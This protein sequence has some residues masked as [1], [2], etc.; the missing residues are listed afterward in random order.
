MA[1]WNSPYLWSDSPLIWSIGE[2]YVILDNYTVI[3]VDNERYLFFTKDS[4]NLIS[5]DEKTKFYSSDV[6]NERIS[7]KKT[8]LKIN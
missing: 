2:I 4:I 8:I 5:D 1:N 6:I 7:T 3:K